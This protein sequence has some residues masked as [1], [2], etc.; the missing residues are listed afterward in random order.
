MREQQ[1]IGQELHDGLGQEL[2]GISYMAQNLF[3][4][5]KSQESATSDSAEE[6]AKGIRTVVGQIQKIVRGLVP[7]EMDGTGL[8]PALDA[9]T[10]SVRDRQAYSAISVS[11]DAEAVCDDGVAVQMYRIA[12]EA[13]TNAMKHSQAEN[14]YVTFRG[15]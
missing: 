2:T 5:L 12:Q 9:L 13:I 10:S 14:V 7:L 8:G 4:K 11:R 15:E 1:R 6:L 3:V